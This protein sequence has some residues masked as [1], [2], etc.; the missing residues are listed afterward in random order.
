MTEPEVTVHEAA[1]PA[2]PGNVASTPTRRH[3]D[4]PESSESPDM[5]PGDSDPAQ[6]SPMSFSICSWM[7]FSFIQ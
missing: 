4:P 5:S 3:A 1:P 7:D 6:I 2:P